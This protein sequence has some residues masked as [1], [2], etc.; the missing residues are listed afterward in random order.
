MVWAAGGDRPRAPLPTS[1]VDSDAHTVAAFVA[2]LVRSLRG[3]TWAQI[4]LDPTA[5][6]RLRSRH[7]AE[8]ATW[9]GER[10]RWPACGGG[11]GALLSELASATLWSRAAYGHAMSDG[12]MNSAWRGASMFA[13][14]Y[15]HF[16]VAS[17]DNVA[18]TAAL[19]RLSGLTGVRKPDLLEVGEKLRVLAAV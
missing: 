8:H 16:D 11:G 18:N 2:A 7:A 1:G 4:P 6:V 10:A 14:S 15:L 3:R 13:T 12:Q 9:L 19:R 5:L 17:A